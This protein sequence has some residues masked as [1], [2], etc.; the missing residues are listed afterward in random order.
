MTCLLSQGS[1]RAD[2]CDLVGLCSC[3]GVEIQIR[4]GLP[5]VLSLACDETSFGPPLLRLR[6][7]LTALA[8]PAATT[9]AFR[10]LAGIIVDET[11]ALK[12]FDNLSDG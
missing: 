8:A 6:L 3:T 4:L 10:H 5:T 7:A 1:L 9:F 11:L 2:R 12:P